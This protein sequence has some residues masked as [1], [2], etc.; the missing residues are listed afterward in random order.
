M[1]RVNSTGSCSDATCT[2]VMS[3]QHTVVAKPCDCIRLNYISASRRAALV[4][5]LGT[6]IAEVTVYFAVV[7]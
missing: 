1:F 2:N 5:N 7:L 4:V 3:M 6:E